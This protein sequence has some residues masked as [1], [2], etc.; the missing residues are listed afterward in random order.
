V[1]DMN[2]LPHQMVSVMCVL[3]E[4]VGQLLCRHVSFL[5][6]NASLENC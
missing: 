2:F 5:S 6:H 1:M 4:E 3:G